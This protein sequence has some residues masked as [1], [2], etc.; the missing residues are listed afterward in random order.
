[1]STHCTN[2]S[3]DA[4]ESNQPAGVVED[5]LR[6]VEDAFTAKNI[7]AIE[8]LFLPNGYLRE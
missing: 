8:T 2:V 7:D 6:R 4:T 5:F 3:T 1:M